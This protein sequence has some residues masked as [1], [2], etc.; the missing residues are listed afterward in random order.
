MK[1]FCIRLSCLLIGSIAL[2]GQQASAAQLRS[3]FNG[4][5]LSGWEGDTTRWSV[6]NGSIYGQTT[7]DAPVLANTFLTWTGGEV[8]DFEFTCKVKFEGNNSGVQYRSQPFGDSGHALMG[9]QAD[10]HPKPEYF[11]MMYGEKFGK[12]GIIAQRHSRIEVGKDGKTKVIQ[13]VAPSEELVT[14]EW[15]TLQIVAVG[16]RL[17]HLVNGVITVDVTDNHPDAMSKGKLGLQL[18]RGNPMTVEFKDLKIRPLKGRLANQILEN[19][20]GNFPKAS[21]TKKATAKKKLNR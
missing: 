20:T 13:K 10:L 1:S 16:N 19:V 4:K 15:N 3:I 5:D 12:R 17:I 18:H 8:S 9:Y 2:L 21:G 7:K 11:G 6:K 14:T